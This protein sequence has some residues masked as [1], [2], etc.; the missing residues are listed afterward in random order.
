VDTSEII[1]V[2]G[3]QLIT[4]ERTAHL[5]GVKLASLATALSRGDLPLTRYYRGRAPSFDLVEV[6]KVILSKA[7]PAGERKR[8]YRPPERRQEERSGRSKDNS[9]GRRGAR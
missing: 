6:E 3:K 5:L 8:V 1:V 7:V 4:R 2:S 9:L